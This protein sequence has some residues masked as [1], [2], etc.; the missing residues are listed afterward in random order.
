MN[1]WEC[2]ALIVTVPSLS[3]GSIIHAIIWTKHRQKIAEMKLK[4][5]GSLPVE[6]KTELASMRSD[7]HQ[8]RDTTMQYDLSFDTAL[9]QMDRRLG[10]IEAK[11]SYVEA[12]N[13]QE[14]VSSRY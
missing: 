7:I 12:E 3:L 13:P 5:S 1:F 9:Q 10:N 14:K 2:V 4:N 8:L 11:K 6:L